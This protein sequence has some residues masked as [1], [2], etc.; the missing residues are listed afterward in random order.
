MKTIFYGPEACSLQMGLVSV[1]DYLVM[2]K[3]SDIHLKGI[4]DKDRSRR[5]EVK[6]RTMAKEV[7][8]AIQKNT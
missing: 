7:L 6:L 2:E 8:I 5:V 3:C 1:E 4:E